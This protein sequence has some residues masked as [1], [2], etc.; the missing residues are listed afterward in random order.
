MPERAAPEPD[1]ARRRLTRPRKRRAPEWPWRARV[2]ASRCCMLDEIL[3][4]ISFSGG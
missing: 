1:K 3:A 4:G 2:A